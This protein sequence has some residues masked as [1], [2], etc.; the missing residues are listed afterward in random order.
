[1][2]KLDISSSQKTTVIDPLD[3]YLQSAM[4]EGV[5]VTGGTPQVLSPLKLFANLPTAIRQQTRD[6][7]RMVF[8]ALIKML[9]IDKPL[10]APSQVSGYV[11]GTVTIPLRR[12]TDVTGTQGSL[13]FTD[14]VLTGY[15]APT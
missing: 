12:L 3:A 2:A 5:Q 6:S 15:V 13:T 9:G 4:A 11:S 14:G 10:T 1:M 7:Y 8:A